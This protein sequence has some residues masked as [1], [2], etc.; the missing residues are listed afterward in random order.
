MATDPDPLQLGQKYH[1]SSEVG[2]TAAKSRRASL[3]DNY[4]YVLFL[5]FNSPISNGR[6]S[7]LV[8]IQKL[9]GIR[10]AELPASS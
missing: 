3:E 8:T 7:F 2:T 6:A 5:S 9:S 1:R 10:L 4:F